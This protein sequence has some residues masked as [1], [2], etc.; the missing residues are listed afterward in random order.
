M[1]IT[2]MHILYHPQQWFTIVWKSDST[3]PIFLMFFF[4]MGLLYRLMICLDYPDRVPHDE[5][6]A[7]SL[8]HC[9]PRI[10]GWDG[11]LCLSQHQKPRND[12]SRIE[13]QAAR[14]HEY[15]EVKHHVIYTYIYIY[16]DYYYYIYICDTLLIIYIW[17]MIYIILQLF[18]EL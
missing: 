9:I 15:W 2:Y 14:I 6:R 3:F 12:R 7:K 17:Y 18:T 11:K 10:L 1:Y 8:C 13:R 4:L 16:D 5:A